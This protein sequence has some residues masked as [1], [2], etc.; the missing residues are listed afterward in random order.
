MKT[1]NSMATPQRK[2]RN[3]FQ[4]GCREFE[5]RP[6]LHPQKNHLSGEFPLLVASF[7]RHLIV[8]NKTPRTV[9]GYL[10]A[11][12]LLVGFLTAHGMPND[13]GDL[14][15]EHVEDFV[16]DILTRS[17]PATASIRYRAPQQFFK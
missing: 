15:P 14:T 10:E 3:A 11:I 2:E 17:K 8:A 12:Q 9:Q 5:S 6:P 1:P 16:A 13:V 4:A 7:R